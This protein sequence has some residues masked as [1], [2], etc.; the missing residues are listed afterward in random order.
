MYLFFLCNKEKY[1]FSK[2][3]YFDRFLLPVLR[4]KTFNRTYSIDFV[5][6]SG[7]FQE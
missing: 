6:F 5:Q 4:S 2:L 7:T 3:L 1:M